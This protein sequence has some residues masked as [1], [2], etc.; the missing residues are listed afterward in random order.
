MRKRHRS[1]QAISLM[2]AVCGACLF[3]GVRPASSL[4]SAQ[5]SSATVTLTGCL[6][7]EGEYA[8]DRGLART[9]DNDRTTIQLIFIP[10]EQSRGNEPTAATSPIAYALTGPNEQRLA[11]NVHQEVSLDGVVE[12]EV[13]RSSQAPAGSPPSGQLTPNG[14]AGVTADG[15]PAHEPTD[16]TGGRRPDAQ[17]VRPDGRSA[18]V[19]ELDRINVTAARV[20]G[21][22]CRIP[23]DR[24]ATASVAPSTEAS[25]ARTPR[26]NPAAAT[27]TVTGCLVQQEGDA[28]VP[29][30]LTLLASANDTRQ[31]S[32]RSAVPGSLPSGAGSGTIG[33][34]GT[35]AGSPAER[36]TYRLTGDTRTL[37]Q[38]VGQRVEVTGA[39]DLED[40]NAAVRGAQAPEPASRTETPAPETAH[41]SAAQRAL[42]VSTF[43]P[44]GGSCR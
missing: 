2:T 1:R 43:K 31:S 44:L 38:Y 18:S 37:G 34:S 5:Q 33:T 32:A 8:S 6:V 10:D 17:S 16:A 39:E 4:L 42:R 14:A 26:P 9:T 40:G 25:T 35:A 20:I 15:S 28:A 7:E 30:G 27:L 23:R 19:N 36:P 12:R 24:V 11:R 22:A 41:P 13:L 21:G 29:G 3:A